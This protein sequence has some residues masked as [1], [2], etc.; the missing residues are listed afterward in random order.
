MNINH[1]LNTKKDVQNLFFLQRW[2]SN[3]EKISMISVCCH[4]PVIACLFFVGEALDWPED[5]LKNIDSI[6]K[7]YNYKNIEGIPDSYP[8]ERI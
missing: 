3:V 2:G 7:D 4:I 6:I 5:I 1:Y 8:G